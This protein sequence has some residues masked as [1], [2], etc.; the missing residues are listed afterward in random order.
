MDPIDVSGT[1]GR[2]V[3]L[4]YRTNEN[5]NRLQFPVSM[6]SC[7]NET[8]HRYDFNRFCRRHNS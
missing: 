7:G 2:L 6:T 5:I 3:A 4:E 1:E 8:R